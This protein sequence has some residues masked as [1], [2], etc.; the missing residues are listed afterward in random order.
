MGK[1]LFYHLTRDPLEVTAHNLLSRAL[2]QEM[3]VMVRGRDMER[4]T[5]LDAALW[6]GDKASFLPHGL[7]GGRHDADQPILLSTAREAP[8]RAHIIMAIDRAEAT[9]EEVPGLERLWVLFNGHDAEELGQARAQWK[10]MTAAGVEAEYWSQES[11]RWECK[12][13]SGTA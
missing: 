6:Q 3:R 4:L 10:A 8:N 7:A 13:R 11:G 9:P 5:G 2:A 1:A 12:A